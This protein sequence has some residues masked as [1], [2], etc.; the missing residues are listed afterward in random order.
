MKK[1]SLLVPL[2]GLFVILGS[3]YAL[4][5]W[6]KIFREKTLRTLFDT[7][8][9]LILANSS[10]LLIAALLLGL[11][12]LIYFQE[13]KSRTVG[14][15]YAVAGLSSIFYFVLVTPL[16]ERF[17]F[18]YLEP[19]LPGTLTSWASSF[20]A[21]VGLQLLFRQATNSE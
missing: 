19:L 8:D 12:W 14:L 1:S 18:P 11:L 15:I 6:N 2:I 5:T 21:V 9:W 4:D 13:Y 7:D 16:L 17:R 10:Q 3:A 20:L